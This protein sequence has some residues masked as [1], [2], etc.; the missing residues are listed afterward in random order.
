MSSAEVILHRVAHAEIDPL[1]GEDPAEFA[2][3]QH[4]A[5]DSCAAS[6]RANPRMLPFV[7]TR[8]CMAALIGRRPP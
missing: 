5:L 1:H 4:L 2:R 6:L 3:R 7:M 8:F